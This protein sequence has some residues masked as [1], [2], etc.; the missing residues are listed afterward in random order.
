MLQPASACS[1]PP[2]FVRDA[3]AESLAFLDSFTPAPLE[4]R[5]LRLAGP[6]DGWAEV[7]P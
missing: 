7:V 5:G 6:H 1:R 4:V 2:R 3:S